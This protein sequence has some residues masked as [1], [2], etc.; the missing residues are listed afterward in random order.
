M[1]DRKGILGF[2]QL[3][4]ECF[5]ASRFANSLMITRDG[6]A[7]C[8]HLD[9]DAI[10]VAYGLF[11]AAKESNGAYSIDAAHDHDRVKGGPFIFGEYGCG[12]DFEK[13][14]SWRLLI[15]LLILF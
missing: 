14:V 8:Q 2:T 12:I 5:S 11:W 3:D 13:Y 1:F 7:N 9:N 6:F 4:P 15:S 10:P